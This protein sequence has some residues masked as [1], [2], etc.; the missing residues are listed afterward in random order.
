[1]LSKMGFNMNWPGLGISS[2][3]LMSIIVLISGIFLGMKNSQAQMDGSDFSI[4]SYLDASPEVQCIHT[5]LLPQ[6][7]QTITVTA[8]V[9]NGS[10]APEIAK[11]IEIVLNTS[12]VDQVIPSK[13]INGSS[14][15]NYTIGPF[16]NLTT[17]S[18]GCH[19]IDNSTSALLFTGMR[20]I[21]I[22][23]FNESSRAIPILFTGNR[24]SNMDILFIADNR[25]FSSP[26][27]PNFLTDVERAILLYYNQST[28]L[29]NQNK[30]NFWIAQDMGQ[31]KNNC[32]SIAPTNWYSEYLSFDAAVILHRDGSIRDCTMNDKELSTANMATLATE[33]NIL[34]HEIGHR[35]FGLADEYDSG[36]SYESSSP[37]QNVYNGEQACST[38]ALGMGKTCRKIPYEYGLNQYFTSDGKPNDLMVD[39][40]RFEDLDNRRIEKWFEN[41]LSPPDSIPAPPAYCVTKNEVRT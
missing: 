38:D 25:S 17:L 27:D 6:A 3:I 11:S 15:L 40:G 13:N 41:C 4:D 1:M 31:A 32:E 30:T 2:A 28:L 22:G 33:G 39:N 34:L 35:P 16:T 9:V 18:Y 10:L 37:W 26:T 29:Q 5:P 24:S 23:A 8:S 36:G 7:N 20:T 14:S 12:R 19:A 21:V